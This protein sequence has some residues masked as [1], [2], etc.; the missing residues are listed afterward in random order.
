MTELAT[1]SGWDLATGTHM[2][3]STSCLHALHDGRIE[4]H[5]HCAGT[6]G[7]CGDKHPARC[8]YCVATCQ[9]MCHRQ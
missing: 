8:K 2:Y 5:E 6:V 7:T 1:V 3:F 9:C 4:L